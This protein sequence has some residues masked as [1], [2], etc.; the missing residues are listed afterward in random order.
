LIIKAR[1]RHTNIYPCGSKKS[2]GDC[3][4]VV[5][6]KNKSSI[7]FWY[8]SDDKSTHLVKEEIENA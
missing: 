1:K 6:L 8:D 4:T 7:L 3:F 5:G 2:F